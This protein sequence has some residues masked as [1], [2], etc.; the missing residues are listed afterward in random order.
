MP[1]EAKSWQGILLS[2]LLGSIRWGF[3][4]IALGSEN[5]E[6]WATPSA[7]SLGHDFN[8]HLELHLELH[9]EPYL[10]VSLGQRST[11]T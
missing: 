2:A 4:N 11:R 6:Q 9:R 8:L 10:A 7:T 1:K 5:G 3:P